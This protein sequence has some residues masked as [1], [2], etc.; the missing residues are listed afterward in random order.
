MKAYVV[1]GSGYSGAELLRILVN[2]PK[3]DELVTSS[4]QY[5]GQKV[6]SLHK[7]LSGMFE[8]EFQEFSPE[9][10]DADVVFL[11]LPH[12][13]SMKYAPSLLNSGSKVVD[14]SADYRLPLDAYEEA[15]VKHENSELLQEAVYGLPELYRTQIKGAS[16]VAN[17][18][19]YPTSVILGLAPLSNYP[20]KLDLKRIVV[21]SLSGTSGAGANPSQFLHAS[22]VDGTIKPYK[23]IG[24]RHVPEMEVYT[25]KE[26]GENVRISFTPMLAPFSRGILSCITVSEVENVVGLKGAYEKA[27]DKEKFIRI[28]DD[29]NIK[30]VVNTNF[31]DIAV[32]DERR[33]K[34]LK[35]IS[36]IDN[37]V[38]GAAGQAV[39]N[40]NLMM[41]Y[42][43]IESLTQIS[44]HP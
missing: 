4:R 13:E 40:M 21:T 5:V 1:G 16:L 8:G 3:V 22:E 32:Y 12:G 43:E 44:G 25:S 31:C 23:V 20:K 38:K 34:T 26:L 27:Y 28:V 24:H 29:A 37:L 7:N 30:N 19:C 2:H 18:G 14:L 6:A 17:P 15:Y 42:K 35:I 10:I 9:K 11:A 33:T 41:G 36:V 39:Q